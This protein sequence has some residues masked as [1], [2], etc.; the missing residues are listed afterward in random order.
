MAN[1]EKQINFSKKTAECPLRLHRKADRTSR[2]RGV[3]KITYPS[4]V[5]PEN[6]SAAEKNWLRQMQDINA[7]DYIF[8]RK[9]NFSGNR[10]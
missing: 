6:S 9:I 2:N 3:K 1:P 10:Y 5:L 7:M 8:R 4:D